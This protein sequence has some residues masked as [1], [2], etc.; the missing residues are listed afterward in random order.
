MWN[1]LWILLNAPP[2]VPTSFYGAE[3]QDLTK[4]TDVKSLFLPNQGQTVHL[5][6]VNLHPPIVS[7]VHRKK[8]VIYLKEFGRFFMN[9]CC[10]LHIF[11]YSYAFSYIDFTCMDDYSN[12]QSEGA[13]TVFFFKFRL[14]FHSSFVLPIKD[15]SCWRLCE[16]SVTVIEM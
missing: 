10:F 14:Y 8:N 5:I 15:C 13:Q 11:S 9:W 7:K 6:F 16:W 3:I 1:I 4:L 2:C 12:Y